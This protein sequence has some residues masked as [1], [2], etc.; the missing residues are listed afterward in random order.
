MRLAAAR[1]SGDHTAIMLHNFEF[2]H[3]LYRLA[4]MPYLLGLIESL[5]LTVGPLLNELYRR[6]RGTQLHDDAHHGEV[7]KALR[8]ADA[9]GV[10]RA[11]ERDLSQALPQLLEIVASWASED[12]SA[13]TRSGML[14][15]AAEPRRK[16]AR[17]RVYKQP[18]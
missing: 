10:R 13:R 3:A 2:H 4:N 6:E 17:G 11:I 1:K 9:A 14:S 8:N 7:I 5:W 12:E 16:P 15:A 18:A